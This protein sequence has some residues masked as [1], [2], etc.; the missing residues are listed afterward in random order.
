M[1]HVIAFRTARFDVSTETPNPINSIAGQ[2]VLAWLRDE[3]ARAGYR[4]SEPATEDWGWY[5]DVEA[6]GCVYLVGAS[7]EVDGSTPEVD[8]TV[9]VHRVRSFKDR[10]LGRNRMMSDD[11]LS[12]LIERVVRAD[13][14]MEQVSVERES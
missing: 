6:D 8:W 9:Q 3:L 11:A 2:S 7:G 12:G 10:L 13:S 1:A 4:S 5:M 14:R